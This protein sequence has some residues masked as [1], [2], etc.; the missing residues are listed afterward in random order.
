MGSAPGRSKDAPAKP[1]TVD[2]KGVE[3]AARPDVVDRW[4]ADDL[5]GTAGVMRTKEL[6]ALW[7]PWCRQRVMDP[8]EHEANQGQDAQH[9]Q[10]R[11]QQ[12]QAALLG[13]RAKLKA[14]TLRVVAA[15]G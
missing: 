2:T 4:I 7:K 11:S 13:V 10:A 12:Q 6:R 5:E 15:N 14:P 3:A 1:K 8:K 9:L